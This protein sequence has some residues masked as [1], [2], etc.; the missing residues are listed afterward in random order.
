MALMVPEASSIRPKSKP[1]DQ[2]PAP[3]A[4]AHVVPQTTRAISTSVQLLDVLKQGDSAT[5]VLVRRGD[6]R[7]L[8][9]SD[10]APWEKR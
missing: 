1:Q 7:R 6:V 8:L 4:P 2:T 10:M 3:T 5:P 9:A